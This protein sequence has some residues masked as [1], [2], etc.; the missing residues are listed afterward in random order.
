MSR[1]SR[2]LTLFAAPFPCALYIY[3]INADRRND[4]LFEERMATMNPLIHVLLVIPI[5]Y[6]KKGFIAGV[7]PRVSVSF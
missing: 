6:L 2:C 1:G 7:S 5:V 3:R 4:I